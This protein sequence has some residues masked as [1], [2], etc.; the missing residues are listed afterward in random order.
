MP[1]YARFQQL[2]K[3]NYKALRPLIVNTPVRILAKVIEDQHKPLET[4]PASVSEMLRNGPARVR[5]WVQDANDN[6]VIYMDGEATFEAPNTIEYSGIPEAALDEILSYVT[7][8][9]A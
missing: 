3:F 4:T 1:W 7:G 9:R 6:D 2:K 8:P 5:L